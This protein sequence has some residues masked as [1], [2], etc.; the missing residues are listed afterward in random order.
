MNNHQ[1]TDLPVGTAL[2]VATSQHGD[3]IL[4]VNQLAM[5]H[6]NCQTTFS[7]I[8]FEDFGCRVFDKAPKFSTASFVPHLEVQGHIFPFEIRHGLAYL[9][10]RPPTARDLVSLPRV[11]VTSATDWDPSKHD[12]AWHRED[13][14]AADV[15]LLHSVP[16]D[17]DG[18]I[19][20]SAAARAQRHSRSIDR[21]GISAFLTAIA[22]STYEAHLA[23]PG[24]PTLINGLNTRQAAPRRSKL[25]NI[26]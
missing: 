17:Y 3:V 15:R 2:T 20:P 14:S 13:W 10:L 4:V 24:L 12:F 25:V 19:L 6:G 21:A 5:M 26:G 11:V 18:N 1:V 7:C 16:F 23:Y 22:V 9:P 8:Q